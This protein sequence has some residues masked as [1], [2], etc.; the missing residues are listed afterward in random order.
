MYFIINNKYYSI[1]N[2]V[3]FQSK[4]QLKHFMQF[5]LILSN[6]CGIF[7]LLTL[8]KDCVNTQKMFSQQQ[9][10]QNLMSLELLCK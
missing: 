3:E 5:T 2:V 6:T 4:L 9:V 10:Q 8:L 1:I 7:A